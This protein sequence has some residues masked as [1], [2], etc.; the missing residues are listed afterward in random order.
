MVWLILGLVIFLGIHSVR[1]FA[2]GL[3]DAQVKSM[4]LGAWKGTY[5]LIALAGLIFIIWGYGQA[6]MEAGQL[7]VP[8]LWLRHLAV[9]L[10]LVSFVILPLAYLP[11]GVLKP[12]LKHPMLLAVKIWA[13]AHLLANGDSASMLLFG[14]FLAWA[15]IDRISVKRRGEPLPEPGPLMNDIIAVVSGVVLWLLCIL[16]AHDFLVGV[17]PSD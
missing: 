5:S 2:P 17:M 7:W 11:S 6:R 4:G 9:F 8:S 15:V 10:M 13:L 3:R 12:L 14:A 16:W 1:I